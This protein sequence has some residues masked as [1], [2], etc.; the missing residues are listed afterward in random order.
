MKIGYLGPEGTYSYEAAITYS[1]DA[2]HIPFK[3]FYEIIHAVESG[4][5]EEGVLPIE[6]STEG[7]VTSVM[8]GLL[9]TDTAKIKG[10]LILPVVHNL[11]SLS[12]DIKTIRYIYSHPQAIEQCRDYFQKYLP[13][14]IMLPCESTSHACLKAKAEGPE[15]G[16]IGNRSA[17]EIHNL[18]VLSSSIQDNSYNQTRF[19]I[20]SKTPVPSAVL[21][22]TSIVFAFLNDYPGSLYTVLKAFAD[23]NINLTRIESR[24]AKAELGK[25]I[26]YIDFM[27]HYKD[28]VVEEVLSDIKQITGFLKIFG[29]YPTA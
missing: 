15:K 20:I 16:A 11:L 26:F 14:V 9:K 6:N 5:I 19:I 3:S 21:N 28:P 12:N 8:D 4:D 13:H 7:A 23:E 22:K 10:E 17:A 2:H 24:P 29:S 27:G 18:H 1:P 25:Y